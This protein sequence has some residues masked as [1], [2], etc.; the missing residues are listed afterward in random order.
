MEGEIVKVCHDGKVCTF[1]LELGYV[2]LCINNAQGL[3]VTVKCIHVQN[4]EKVLRIWILLRNL[5]IETREKALEYLTVAKIG[6]NTW[7]WS[8]WGIYTFR[9]GGK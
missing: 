3:S 8:L 5:H 7:S 1:K 6:K 9:I 4:R 2:R